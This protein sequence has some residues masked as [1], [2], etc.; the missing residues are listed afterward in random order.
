M[1]GFEWWGSAIICYNTQHESIAELQTK[2]LL[3]PDQQDRQLCVLQVVASRKGG[4]PCV[5][6][7]L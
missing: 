6:P 2:S 5:T 1:V 7:P 3:S 4:G